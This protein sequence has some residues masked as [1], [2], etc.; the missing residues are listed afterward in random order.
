[1][2]NTKINAK[3]EIN[4]QNGGPTVTY[5]FVHQRSFH[6]DLFIGNPSFNTNS[7]PAWVTACLLGRIK[8]PMKLRFCNHP[9]R[10]TKR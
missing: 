4:K 10:K 3:H 7:L 6:E 9:V 1:M 5:I 2:K 8:V